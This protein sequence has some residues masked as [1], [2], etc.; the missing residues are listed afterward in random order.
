MNRP[1]L[2]IVFVAAVNT[3]ALDELAELLL[4]VED[5]RPINFVNSKTVVWG[6]E[7]RFWHFKITFSI[8]SSVSA[9]VMVWVSIFTPKN[10]LFCDG[11][12][13][14]DFFRFMTKTRCWSRKTKVPLLIKMSS[15]VLPTRRISLRYIP[16]RMFYCLNRAICTLSSFENIL[17]AGPNSKQR[18]RNS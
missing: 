18:Q 15:N 17:E 10:S 9:K 3:I 12:F 13:K 7:R 11:C 1:G 2:L 4:R 8:F 6:W 5:I 14:T 16:R